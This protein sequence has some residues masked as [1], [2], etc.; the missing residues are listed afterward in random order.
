MLLL[1]SMPYQSWLS[2]VHSSF[3]PFTLRQGSLSCPGG[4]TLTSLLSPSECLGL[5]LVLPGLTH[6]SLLWGAF[7]N[8]QNSVWPV[9]KASH[10]APR[11]LQCLPHPSPDSPVCIACGC[12]LNALSQCSPST[13]PEQSEFVPQQVS[14]ARCEAEMRRF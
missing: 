9:F 1:I 13:G 5:L 14:Q 7:L 12:C 8:W 6:L 4:L 3:L 11:P 2:A 10:P